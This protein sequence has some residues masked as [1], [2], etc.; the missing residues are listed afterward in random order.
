MNKKNNFRIW[1]I[2]LIFF[3]FILIIILR[4]FYLQIIM[5]DFYKEQSLSQQK[6]KIT[7]YPNRGDILDRNGLPLAFSTKAYSVYLDPRYKNENKELILNEMTSI[8]GFSKQRA[9]EIFSINSYIR[10]LPKVPQ[11][12]AN[13]LTAKGFDLINDTIR[14]YPAGNLAS[15]LLGYVDWNNE[16]KSGLERNYNKV[17]AGKSG[18][19]ILESDLKGR[20][21]FTDRRRILA[22][23]DGINIETTIDK[24]L[25]FIIESILQEKVEEIEAKSSSV[26]L[27]DINSGEIYAMATYPGYD[28]NNF[29]SYWEKDPTFFWNRAIFADYEPGSIM[30]LFTVASALEE[31]IIKHDDEIYSPKILVI[32]GTTIKEASYS[33]DKDKSN[34]KNITEIISKSLN[35]GAAKIGIKLGKEKLYKYLDKL[36]FG[37]NTG[38]GL[39]EERTGI[40][41][42]YSKWYNVDLS[43]ISF[44]YGITATPLQ[45]IRAVGVIAN[46]GELIVP[47]ILKNNSK[48]KKERIYNKETCLHILE[49]MK[50]GVE[51]GTGHRAKIDKYNI[52]GKTGTAIIFSPEENRYLP[53][54]Y[55]S[56]FV[57]IFP[58][59]KPKFAM[60]VTVND[61]KKDKYGS[62]APSAI[63]NEITKRIIRYLK[64]DPSY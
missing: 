41:S 55:N 51:D 7:L 42:N 44:G 21:I 22:V 56:S 43:R 61:A 29:S 35:V 28:P 15:Q 17:L 53:G 5:H 30:K 31:K 63:F 23:K 36:G 9:E 26:I 1:N 24:N 6:R 8:L 27:M 45:L 62:Q 58:I 18:Y 48:T 14:N 13:L 16:G 11:D 34:T 33:L 50:M 57:G 46:G 64:I 32:D 49:M 20:S 47:T 40:L 37:K 54:R 19:M 38:I 12:V 39:A 10:V 60:I 25:Q 52:G 2:Y 59:D 4:M 3:I